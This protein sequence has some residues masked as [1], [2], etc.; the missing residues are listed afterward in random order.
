LKDNYAEIPQA[1]RPC[2]WRCDSMKT[3]S[4]R[5]DGVQRRVVAPAGCG[6]HLG[7]APFDE[8]ERARPLRRSGFS[9]MAPP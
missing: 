8:G 2:R 4:A 3:G 7:E 6:A 9:D 1:R 5:A